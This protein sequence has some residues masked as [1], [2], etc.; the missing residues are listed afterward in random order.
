MIPEELVVRFDEQG[1]VVI[2]DLL[3]PDEVAAFVSHVDEAVQARNACDPRSL[4]EKTHYEQSFQQCINIWED[5]P[6]VRPLTFHPAVT[7]AAAALLGV[8]SVRLWHDQALYEEPGG[9]GTDAHQDQPYWPIV[10][11]RTVTAWIPLVDVSLEMGAMGYIPGSHRFGVRRFANIFT[12]TGFDLVGGPEARGMEPVHAAVKR[13]DVA[14]HH[15]LTIHVAG[16][17]RTDR[18]R[19]A[20]TATFLADGCTRAEQP[21]HHPSVDRGHVATGAPIASVVTPVAHPRPAGHL[22]ETPPPPDSPIRAW[23]GWR[24]PR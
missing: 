7:A 1:V 14:F 9:R 20:H 21:C 18:L 22:P 8:E 3:S 2:P 19:R 15:G 23:P 12:E 4:A 10:E 5:F 17:N 24:P 6:A 13:G 16:A 11:P